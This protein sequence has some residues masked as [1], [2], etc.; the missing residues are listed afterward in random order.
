MN[1]ALSKPAAAISGRVLLVDDDEAHR[2][3]KSR[4]L[5]QAGYEVVEATTGAQAL[6]SLDRNEP[7][8]VLLD[9]NLP[10]INGLEVCRRIKQNPATKLIPVLQMSASFCDDKSKV[11]GLEGGADGY[12][13]DPIEPALLIAT[14]AA[15]MRM[16]QAEQA[17]RE[18][19]LEWQTTFDAIS[20]GVALVDT[21]GCILRFNRSLS[22]LV[23]RP[24]N[25][26]AGAPFDSLFPASDAPMTWPESAGTERC[27]V[28]RSLGGRMFSVTVDPA[29][30]NQGQRRGAVAIVRDIT[31]RKHMDEQLWHTQKL[32]GIGVLAGGV[33][34]DFNNLLTGILGNAS[35]AL[36]TLD[37]RA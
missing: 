10:D 28:E 34:H 31:E 17:V 12:V 2:Y 7:D 11:A 4:V 5:R 18:L 1:G 13:T 22:S 33:A 36:E 9:V 3:A 14:I 8:L 16:H 26:L 15:F 23:G 32:E 24:A 20:D 19:A 21:A 29:F 35:L 37:D 6:S 27:R 25:E 30:G